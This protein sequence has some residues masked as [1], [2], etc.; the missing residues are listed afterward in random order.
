M[1]GLNSFIYIMWSGSK[2]ISKVRER[3][4]WLLLHVLNGDPY[5]KILA[6]LILW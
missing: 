1:V 4:Y 2:V 6:F 5:T 3:F